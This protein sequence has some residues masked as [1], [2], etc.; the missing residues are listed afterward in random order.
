MDRRPPR[1][2]R[3]DTLFPSPTLVRS[4][5]PDLAALQCRGERRRYMGIAA[6]TLRL[7]GYPVSQ[8][9][10]AARAALIEK[11]TDFQVI[12]TRPAQDDAFLAPSPMGKIPYQ[13]GRASCRESVGQDV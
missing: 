4:P 2:T 9:F 1:S 6:M 11:G 8:Y 13:Y 5:G 7:H 3:T 12:P 10:N